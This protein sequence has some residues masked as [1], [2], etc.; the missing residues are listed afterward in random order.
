MFSNERLGSTSWNGREHKRLFW[1]DGAGRFTDVA[2]GMGL[3]V[4]EDGRA[5]IFFDMDGDGDLDLLLTT[6]DDNHQVRLFRNE[7]GSAKHWLKVLPVGITSN[8]Q[9]VG[10]LIRVWAGGKLMVRPVVAGQGYESSYCGPIH[11]GLGENAEADR[12][13]VVFPDGKSVALTS[14]RSDQTVTVYQNGYTEAIS[15]PAMPLVFQ[16]D[17]KGGQ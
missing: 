12:V 8:R 16:V 10:S 7:M 17:K 13:E 5:A 6:M 4:E 11:F 2:F 1:N 14:V 3:D 9:A 15:S